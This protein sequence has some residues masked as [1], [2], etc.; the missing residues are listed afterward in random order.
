MDAATCGP[1]PNPAAALRPGDARGRNCVIACLGA[2]KR[3]PRQEPRTAGAPGRTGTAASGH[4]VSI[5]TAAP[6][7][8]PPP[9]DAPRSEVISVATETSRAM[10][11]GTGRFHR[12]APLRSRRPE[13]ASAWGWVP[14]ALATG[15]SRRRP[16]R[17]CVRPL[18]RAQ[19]G[20]LRAR[21]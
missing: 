15:D 7:A 10:A 13:A 14:G 4:V 2:H 12:I 18:L 5:A 17:R 3:A 6:A 11:A 19:L 1:E 20:G 16:A 21:L 9:P 8:E